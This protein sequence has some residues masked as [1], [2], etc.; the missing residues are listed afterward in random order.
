M[1][2]ALLPACGGSASPTADGGASRAPEA[3]DAAAPAPRLPLPALADAGTWLLSQ[4][5]LYADIA[6]GVL[7][8]GVEAFEPRYP[9]WSD[10]AEKRRF[11]ALPPGTQIDTSDMDHWKFPVGTR[12]WKQF[13]RGG[14]RIETRLIER[15]G[16]DDMDTWMA[17]F[18][19]DDQGRD[20]QLVV[21]GATDVHGTD[22]DVPAAK[23]CWS[24]HGAEPG[25][26]LGFSALQ[27]SAGPALPAL[28][29]RGLLSHPPPEGADLSPPG[30]A[31]TREALGTLHANCGTCHSDGGAARP[32]TNMIL[33][34]AVAERD[35][36]STRLAA[37]T[38]GVDVTQYKTD[39]PPLRIAPGDPAGSAV[40]ARMHLRERMRQMPPLLTKHVDE[41]GLAL[42]QR[43]IETLPRP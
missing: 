34:L 26:V 16:P 2:L 3:A 24:C 43:W 22:H 10:G 31:V 12:L 32:K 23:V 4:T 13:S 38:L 15:T 21:D 35:P 33:R 29:A 7:A 30:D 20:A 17:A 6:S 18:L 40:I 37:T 9:L 1:A 25:R 5:G 14:V 11:I 19:W 28:V 36:L 41:A 8:P 42:V 39:G 27:L